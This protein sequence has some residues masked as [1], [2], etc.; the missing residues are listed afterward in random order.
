MPP[1]PQANGTTAASSIDDEMW[2]E[3]M[4][5]PTQRGHQELAHAALRRL[6]CVMTPYEAPQLSSLRL[7]AWS[8]PPNASESMSSADRLMHEIGLQW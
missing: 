8:P 7:A 1:L 6:S 3:D 4:F 5:H 2:L